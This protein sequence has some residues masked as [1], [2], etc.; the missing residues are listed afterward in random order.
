MTNSLN[1]QY[2]SQ[3][4]FFTDFS[5][6]GGEHFRKKIQLKNFLVDIFNSFFASTK[7]RK[8]R[9]LPASYGSVRLRLNKK[10][11]NNLV[12]CRLCGTTWLAEN[13]FYHYTRTN[14]L[15]VMMYAFAQSC[16]LPASHI[17]P[18]SLQVTLLLLFLNL[19]PKLGWCPMTSLTKAP[20][21]LC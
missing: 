21:Q 14:V 3:L 8:S 11:N 10:K 13:D 16:F 4:I 6:G 12:T 17:V 2:E 9:P 19:C 20:I 15:R 7:R 1:S 18:R 5:S